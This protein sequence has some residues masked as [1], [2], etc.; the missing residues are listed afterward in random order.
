MCTNH[1]LHWF[2]FGRLWSTRIFHLAIK[3]QGFAVFI[4][5]DERD[6]LRRHGSLGDGHYVSIF[7]RPSLG[8]VVVATLDYCVAA[9]QV[10]ELNSDVIL[11]SSCKT[12]TIMNKH[13]TRGIPGISVTLLNTEFPVSK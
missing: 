6:G 10:L 3:S 11:L 7:Y 8:R 2:V 1:E 5:C 9:G 4:Q 12:T 13:R